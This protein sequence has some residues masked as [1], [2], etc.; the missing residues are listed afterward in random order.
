[1][2]L[3]RR[4]RTQGTA[5][6]GGVFA[7][8]AHSRA[9]EQDGHYEAARELLSE[10]WAR[11]GERPRLEGLGGRE[12]VEV[13]LRVGC[14]TGWIGSARQVEG[15]QELSLNLL[16]ECAAELE[17]LGEQSALAEAR[18]G[19]ARA[20]W[21]KASY[22]EARIMLRLVLDRD[23]AGEEQSLCALVMQ[24]VVERSAGDYQAAK[25]LH[26]A[27]APR[28]EGAGIP[29][30]LLATFY[31][32]WALT[33]FKLGDHD[34]ALVKYAVAKEYL[35]AVGD[36]ARLATV[37][38]SLGF[39]YYTIRSLP[40]AIEHTRLAIT[41]YESVSDRRGIADANETL[42]R[43]LVEL[44]DYR[45]AERAALCAV[46]I[47]RAGD[48]KAQMVEALTALGVAQARQGRRREAHAAF[49]EA[50]EE[51]LNYVGK[52]AAAAV[53]TKVIEE[54]CATACLAAGLPLEPPVEAL[55][56]AMIKNALK[57]A[58]K[59]LKE[60]AVR[61][62]VEYDTLRY[63]INTR[64]PELKDV[65]TPVMPRRRSLIK[66]SSTKVS[67]ISEVRRKG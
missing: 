17:S 46:Q 21:R 67:K 64:H 13:L 57:D 44:H 45:G 5:I 33:H 53:A 52:T 10:W 31:Y 15:A 60:A 23:D 38:T 1:M 59:S 48:E 63:M 14:L 12:A 55:E 4:Q 9:L 61:L 54:L 35:E 47:L 16:G 56:R 40:E 20:Y 3:D 32:G 34:E 24:T 29:T 58:N 26:E 25:R 28:F 27:A 30:K 19:M 65:R 37:E 51:A 49:A 6:E 2:R 66:K 41:L 18:I 43:I 62:G 22:D 11:V 39:L 36:V 8:C 42:S 7:T 50:E